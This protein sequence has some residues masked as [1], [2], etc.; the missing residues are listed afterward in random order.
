MK[1]LIRLSG[2]PGGSESSLGAQV[3]LLVLSCGGSFYSLTLIGLLY[4]FV[5][6]RIIS[7]I[8]FPECFVSNPNIVHSN[9]ALRSAASDLGSYYL[10]RSCSWVAS[11]V[12]F[13]F[14]MVLLGKTIKIIITLFQEDNIFGMYASLTYGPQ[15]HKIHVIDSWTG[16]NYLQYVQSRWG[17]HTPSMLRAGYPSLLH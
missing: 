12:S 16:I 15:L 4:P 14:V 9:Q 3:I 6:N 1:T 17:L 10:P 13:V 2:C 8:F 5:L 7:F 11:S